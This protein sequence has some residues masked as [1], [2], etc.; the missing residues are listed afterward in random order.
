MEARL[1]LAQWVAGTGLKKNQVA[2][3][4]RIQPRTLG[5]WISG[6]RKPGLMAR[7]LLETYTSGAV[8]VEDWGNE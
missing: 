6:N 8:K 7:V 1:K 4:M 2:G 5:Q 3:K